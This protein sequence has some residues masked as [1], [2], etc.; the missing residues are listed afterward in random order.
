MSLLQ[1]EIFMNL[2]LIILGFWSFCIA[3]LYGWKKALFTHTWQEP[4][5]AD[6]P[7][8]IE[9]D[10]WGPGSTF[11][12]ER[13]S[14]L[15]QC[16][17]QQTDSIN[18]SAILTAD[19]VLSVPDMQK[20]IAVPEQGY[21]RIFLDEG[22]PEIL[23]TMRNAMKTGTFVPQ[24][25][26]LEH[27]N[28][29]AFARLCQVN[30]PRVQVALANPSEWQWESLES[31]L[32]G[33]YVDGSHE[34][35]QSISLDDAQQ[36]VSLATQTFTR[37]FGYPSLST[38]APCYLWNDDIEKVWKLNDIHYI[39]TAGYRCDGRGIN[40]HYHQDK[41]IIRLGD[42][43]AFGQTYLV[44]N[45]MFEP[46]DGR[47]TPETA[48]QEALS[49]YRQALPLSIST[50][51]YNYT[52]DKVAF[53]ASLAGLDQLLTHIRRTLT[54]TRFVASPEL[55]DAI[56]APNAPIIN[57]FN[58]SQWPPLRQLSGV[59]KLAPFL[60]RLHARHPKLNMLSYLTGLIIPAAI[61]CHVFNPKR[62]NG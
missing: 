31:R 15:L 57:H 40:G 30:D 60:Y 23:Q 36:L 13:L 18:R 43:S 16:L 3:A 29:T 56:V 41:Q 32:Q 47:N 39:Q 59:K 10:D 37:L 14:E 51:R 20:I 11:H 48:Y 6:T 55:A 38:V 1:N 44:R 53:Y 7:I 25:H 22:F 33:H 61:I 34:P 54:N 4:Y 17:D 24:L 28:G 49:V 46:V 58:S 9:S 2:F 5:F 8:L 12:S 27:L 42:S 52:R 26:G 35:S 45:V 50:H 19:M 62:V 21:Q